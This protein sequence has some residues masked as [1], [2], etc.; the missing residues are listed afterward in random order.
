[1]GGVCRR[2]RA[3]PVDRGGESR[4]K[5]ESS[6]EGRGR[7]DSFSSFHQ[8]YQSQI[9]LFSG[10]KAYSRQTAPYPRCATTE[11]AWVQ[12]RE[13]AVT[14]KGRRASF[15][16][17]GSLAGSPAPASISRP[18][19]FADSRFRSLFFRQS[20]HRKKV[21]Q[22]TSSRGCSSRHVHRPPS[23]GSP[24]KRQGDHQHNDRRARH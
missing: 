8:R 15:S 18:I 11:R 13:V 7:S 4:S 10:E 20:T 2:L 12:A 3:I 9:R 14:D 1:M 24:N 21:Q 6:G 16:A 19:F 22:Q 5:G 23:Y 17:C